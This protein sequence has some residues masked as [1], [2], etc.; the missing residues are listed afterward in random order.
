MISLLEITQQT[1][2]LLLYQDINM[3]KKKH[4]V[5]VLV[6]L[7]SLLCSVFD[8]ARAQT[9][10]DLGVTPPT[11]YLKIKPGSQATH[12]ITLENEGEQQL[13]I[14]P[15]IVDFSSDGKTGRPVL[16]ETNSFPYFDEATQNLGS[17]VLSPRAKAQLTIQITVPQDVPNREYPLTVLFETAPVSTFTLSES[18][19][20]VSGVIG[21]NIIILVSD[22]TAVPH[23]LAITS[24]QTWRVVDSFRS[25]TFRPVLENRGY[26][27]T[28]ASGSAQITDWS[29]RVLKEFAIKPAVVLGT[30]QRELE[31]ENG[32]DTESIPFRYK[33]PLLLGLY[34]IQ[35]NLA[36]INTEEPQII[37]LTETIIALPI[38]L[39]LLLILTTGAF[40]VYKWYK[41][42]NLL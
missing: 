33:P 24:L 27:A 22:E 16:S 9:T 28:A 14:T 35:V 7:A 37:A 13:T 19:T 36:S 5:F 20:Q 34:R 12:T 11:A 15:K 40:F 17:L 10:F 29:G 25:I 18:T 26:A 6:V 1:L 32:E 39:I 31:V 41:N 30:S 42:K 38:F 4:G 23:D 8:T 2:Y 21:S 3:I